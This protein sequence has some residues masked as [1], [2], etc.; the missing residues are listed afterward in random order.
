[1]SALAWTF[2][3]IV[4]TLS[5]STAGVIIALFVSMIGDFKRDK[6]RAV[7]TFLTGTGAL[8]ERILIVDVDKQLCI[9]VHG[10]DGCRRNLYSSIDTSTLSPEVRQAV[11]LFSAPSDSG[12]GLGA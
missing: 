1:M 9:E 3:G 6:C 11:R 2:F 10:C 8:K 5:V 12:S 7:L 4:F